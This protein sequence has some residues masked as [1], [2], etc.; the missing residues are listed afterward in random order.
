MV[1][2]WR[3]VDINVMRR[4]EKYE[5]EVQEYEKRKEM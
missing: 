1:L 5:G 3:G 2:N 4:G